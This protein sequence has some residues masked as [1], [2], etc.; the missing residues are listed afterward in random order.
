MNIKKVYSAKDGY[1][2]IAEYY[3]DWK[4]QKF[5]KKNEFPII[6]HWA[7]NLKIGKGL[8]AGTGSGNNLEVFLNIGHEVTALDIS[9]AMLEICKTKYPTFISNG[10]L[11]CLELD[12]LN[13][14]SC[15]H[16]FDWI[17]CNRVLSNIKD[18][19]FVFRVFST[20][21]KDNG[22][23]L[24]SDVHPL[25]EYENTNIVVNSKRVNIET[26]K[27]SMTKINQLILK[28]N[29]EIIDYKEFCFSDLKNENNLIEFEYLGDQKTP[30]FFY[31]ILRKK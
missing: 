13:L 23:C 17:T 25:H 27:H 2:M 31:Y 22:E 1:N 30:I 20:V 26:Y 9:K 29:F 16:S 28:N 5:W 19:E 3:D 10:K 12:L 4:W 18:I 11:D 21:I 6:K 15:R 24:I 14:L 8:D 7:N